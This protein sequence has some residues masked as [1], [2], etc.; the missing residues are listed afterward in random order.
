[1]LNPSF[2]DFTS[3]WFVCP[4]PGET[5]AAKGTLVHGIAPQNDSAPGAE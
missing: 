3:I 4:P 5:L 2:A 1:V